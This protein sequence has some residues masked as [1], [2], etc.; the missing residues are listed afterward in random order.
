[1]AKLIEEEAF[2]QGIEV[3]LG[4]SVESFSGNERVEKVRTDK[5]SYDT[6]IVVL[7]IGVKPNTEF[8]QKTDLHLLGNGA[9]IVNP[10]METSLPN[11]YAAGDCATHYHRIKKT[12]DYVALGTTSNKQGRIAGAN[13]AG[14]TMTRSEEHTSE[15]QSRGQSRMPSSA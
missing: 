12:N 10:Y 5:N 3:I 4:E 14:N 8:L 9:I 7:G 11:I 6:N 2:N 13:M 15:L 1:M